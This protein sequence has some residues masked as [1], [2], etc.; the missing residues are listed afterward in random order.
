LLAKRIGL[1]PLVGFLVTGFLINLSGLN[2]GEISTVL[3]GLSDLGVMLLLFTI[4]LKIKL[5][6]LFK[7]EVWLTASVHMIITLLA[8]SGVIFLLS[9]TGLSI[10]SEL[11]TKSS[12]MIGFALSFSSTVF[13]VKIL[14]DRGELD[15][16]HG[17]IAIGILIVQD[18]FAVVFIAIS[19]GEL[20]GLIVLSLPVILYGVKFILDRILNFLD[21]GEMITVFGFFSTFVAGAA[22]FNFV[23]LK[24]DLGALV[25]GMLLVNHSKANELYER[26]MNYKDFFLIA[27]FINIGL[28]GIPTLESFGISM[29]LLPIILLKALLFIAILARFNL[30]A[31]TAF[32]T[33]MSLANYS[34]FGLIVSVVGMNLGLISEE[35]LIIIAMLMTF[36]FLISAPLN[37]N[38]HN[39]YDRYKNLI[40]KLNRSEE[41]V[42]DEP[43]FLGDA[44]FMVIGMGRVGT[45]TYKAL[46][47]KFEK[48]VIGIDYR[49]S[50]VDKLE[51]Q[52]INILWGDTTDS[53]LWDNVDLSKIKMIFLAT[54]DFPSNINTLKAINRLP[55]KNFKISTVCHYTDETQKYLDL[56][57]DYVF[58]YKVYLGYDFVDHVLEESLI[59]T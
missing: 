43:A 21:H 19:S 47:N 49:H 17:K 6:S 37:S 54:N 40:S 1:P 8:F 7:P 45:S 5:K 46:E 39:I 41:C 15:A 9:Y 32:L 35:W 4:G 2:E 51:K 33:S 29:I 59:D 44:E 48:K 31:R 30:R 42:D 36:S 28:T 27:F 52:G 12:L 10:L 25:I 23:G 58:D 14:Q 38:A 22:V 53:E 18:I 55:Q 11:D 57:V 34:E 3:Q 50:L 26:M 56:G 24:P 20:P 16:Y 13:V